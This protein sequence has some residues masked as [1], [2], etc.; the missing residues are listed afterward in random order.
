MKGNQSTF[1]L[2]P[3]SNQIEQKEEVRSVWWQSNCKRLFVA[4]AKDAD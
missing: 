1:N 4:A 3:D 2:D